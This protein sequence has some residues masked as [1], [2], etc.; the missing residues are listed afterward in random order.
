MTQ[1]NAT[2]KANESAASDVWIQPKPEGSNKSASSKKH[3]NLS[4]VV[5]DFSVEK[6]KKLMDKKQKKHEDKIKK[7]AQPQA[8]QASKAANLS[9]ESNKTTVAQ[10]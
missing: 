8:S 5:R 9:H 3:K 7:D 1:T 2:A 10:Q 6:Q 4:G